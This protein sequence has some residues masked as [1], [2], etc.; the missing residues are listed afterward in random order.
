MDKVKTSSKLKKRRKIIFQGQ[1]K[2]QNSGDDQ[3]A[4]QESI[5]EAQACS[6]V[7]RIAKLVREGLTIENVVGDL[8]RGITTH[9]QVANFVGHNSFISCVDPQKVYEA[10]EDPDWLEA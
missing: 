2:D 10:L 6:E 9:N 1:D 3:V 5:E 4:S 7:R 8:E